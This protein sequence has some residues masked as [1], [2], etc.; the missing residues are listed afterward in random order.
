MSAIIKI[1]NMHE[2]SCLTFHLLWFKAQAAQFMLF[3][4]KG[5]TF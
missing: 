1:L 2:M 5:F 3:F 4:L